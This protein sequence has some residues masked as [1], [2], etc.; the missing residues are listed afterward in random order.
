MKEAD[1]RSA[2]RFMIG[3]TIIVAL[4]FSMIYFNFPHTYLNDWHRAAGGFWKVVG[5]FPFIGCVLFMW[6]GKELTWGE[7]GGKQYGLISILLLIFGVLSACGW[8]FDLK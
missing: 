2:K 1:D 5:V 3:A 4:I 8:N 7:Q 6:F